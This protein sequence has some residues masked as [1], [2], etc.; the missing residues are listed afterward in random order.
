MRRNQDDHFL[1]EDELDMFFRKHMENRPLNAEVPEELEGRIRSVIRE[2]ARRERSRRRVVRALSAAA[3]SLFI[4]LVC[5]ITLSPSM[6]AYAKEWLGLRVPEAWLDLFQR[7]AGVKEA[8]EHRYEPIPPVTVEKDGITITI[9]NIYLEENKLSFSAAIKG[10]YEA[11]TGFLIVSGDFPDAGMSSSMSSVKG[12]NSEVIDVAYVTQSL[13]EREVD[14]FLRKKPKHLTFKVTQTP[15]NNREQ[16]HFMNIEVPFDASM[17]LRN[18][19]IP[20]EWELIV[21]NFTAVSFDNLTVSPTEMSLNYEVR[22]PEGID[23]SLIGP[24][25]SDDS[26]YMTGSEGNEYAASD[27]RSSKNVISFHPSAYFKAGDELKL[28]INKVWL[29]DRNAKQSFDIRLDGTES[30]PK[31]VQFRGQTITVLGAK[32]AEGHLYLDV[33]VDGAHGDEHQP[34]KIDFDNYAEKMN[35]DPELFRLY[36]E[37]YKV[38]SFNVYGRALP[39]TDTEVRDNDGMYEVVIMAPKQNHYTLDIYRYEDPVELNWT[40]TFKVP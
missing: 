15:G 3:A 25:G 9:E 29:T 19:H 31:T 4:V 1:R 11:Q 13:D 12:E 10:A 23:V 21:E 7:Y 38:Y 36:Q 28:H 39:K 18:K 17:I 27:M 14:E 40:V 35:N 24:Y 5:G 16:R 26:P 2:T 22:A 33:Q 37:E 6:S 32:Y 8:R 20:I 30:Y 34:W